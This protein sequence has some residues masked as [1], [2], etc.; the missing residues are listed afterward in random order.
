METQNFGLFPS[1]RN[2]DGSASLLAKRHFVYVHGI[3]S[4]PSTFNPLRKKLREVAQARQK[5]NPSDCTAHHD[6]YYPY[7]DAMEENGKKLAI[8][9]QT[10]AGGVPPTARSVTLFGHSMGG[11]IARLRSWIQTPLKIA[12]D[13]SSCSAPRTIAPCAPPR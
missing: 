10:L 7:Q 9:L 4:D 1:D 12:L 8:A 11:L 3:R 5:G 2:Q 6:F 13:G